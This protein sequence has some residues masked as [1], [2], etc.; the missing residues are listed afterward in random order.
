M[1][2]AKMSTLASDPSNPDWMECLPVAMRRRQRN[3]PTEAPIAL[4]SATTN[5]KPIAAV[6]YLSSSALTIEF[7]TS[8]VGVSVDGM[9]V[10][11]SSLGV[12]SGTACTICGV[13]VGA[14]VTEEVICEWE[15]EMACWSAKKV[16]EPKGDLADVGRGAWMKDEGADAFVCALKV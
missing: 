3:T 7:R 9:G 14:M 15:G 2:G 11:S 13:G 10:I 6:S 8:G 5:S 1:P 4:S 16:A 12:S